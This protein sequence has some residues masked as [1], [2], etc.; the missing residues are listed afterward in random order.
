MIST[1]WEIAL[2]RGLSPIGERLND[3]REKLLVLRASVRFRSAE[4]HTTNVPTPN[5]NRIDLKEGG[6]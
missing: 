6:T 4:A 3:L 2:H 1:P 5:R